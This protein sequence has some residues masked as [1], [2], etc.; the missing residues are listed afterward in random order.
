M[1]EQLNEIVE[2]F[3]A[4]EVIE[5]RFDRHQIE[6]TFQSVPHTRPSPLRNQRAVYLF[7]HNNTWLRIGQTSYSP[8]FTSQHYGTRRAGSSFAKDVWMNRQEF[9]YIGL[10]TE[11][12]PW[13]CANFGRANIRFPV[14]WGEPFSRFF[15][16]YL[17]LYLNPRFEGRRAAVN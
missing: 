9:E 5:Q 17:H 11:L 12:Q 7:F 16:A 2:S 14:D 6:F 4:I 8:R 13:I 10:E 3:F 15:E 1:E